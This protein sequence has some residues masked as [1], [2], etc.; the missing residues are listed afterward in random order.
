MSPGLGR[1]MFQVLQSLPIALVLYFAD[2]LLFE[3]ALFASLVSVGLAFILL[4]AA[5]YL[6]V[7]RR[8]IASSCVAVRVLLYGGMAAASFATVGLPV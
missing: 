4:P 1:V 6:A 5:V 3:S 8:W 2:T 7:R